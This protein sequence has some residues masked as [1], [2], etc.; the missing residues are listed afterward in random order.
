MS[1]HKF[2]LC[3]W[4]DDQAE[5]AAKFYT[6]IFKDG[7]IGKIQRYGKEGF[8]HHR[9]PEGTAMTI[10]FEANG[11][12]F[13]ALN[14]GPLFKF[15]EAIS[16]VVTCDTQKEI[17][18]YWEKLTG[19]GGKEVQCGWLKDKFGISWQVVPTM[20]QE[21]MNGGDKAGASRAMNAMFKMKKFDIATLQQA[22]KG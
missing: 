2:T 12:K 4:F 21:L 11:Q 9:R 17:D 6:S 8:E 16:I 15:S 1:A 13:I 19:Q 14:G 18:Y 7:K 10:D 20:F 5:E 3:L 22:Y